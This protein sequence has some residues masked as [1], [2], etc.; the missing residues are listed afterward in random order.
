[1]ERRR[2]RVA[3]P[4]A[5]AA[6]L[7]GGNAASHAD[8]VHLAL[9]A[10]LIAHPLGRLLL[11]DQSRLVKEGPLD[12]DAGDVDVARSLEEEV[13]EREV[14][15][16]WRRP[17]GSPAPWSS[18]LALLGGPVRIAVGKHAERQRGC[19]ARSVAAAYDGHRIP[20]LQPHVAEAT[21]TRRPGDLDGAQCS[22]ISALFVPSFAQTAFRIGHFRAGH[23][24]ESIAAPLSGSWCSSFCGPHQAQW[25]TPAAQVASWLMIVSSQLQRYDGQVSIRRAGG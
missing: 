2:G 24:I 6:L 16:G 21:Q 4:G 18:G 20:I 17:F 23:G 5:K 13:A 1:M 22:R 3:E 10:A 14:L 9:G 19:L 11:D 7:D 15:V 12:R 8:V 25:R